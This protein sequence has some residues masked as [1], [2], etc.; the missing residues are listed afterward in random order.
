MLSICIPVFNVDVTILTAEL[1]RQANI[2]KLP[3]EVRIYDDGSIEQYKNINRTLSKNEVVVYYELPRNLGSAAIR[4]KLANDAKYEHLLFLDSD[5]DIPED[6][7]TNYQK[8]INQEFMIVCGG[9]VHPQNLP[10]S[11]YSLRWYVGKKREDFNAKTR[12][13]IPNK[14]FMSNNFMVKK[15]LFDTIRFNEEIKR[16]GHEDTMFGMELEKHNIQIH[17]ID[18]AL[19]HI[20]LENNQEFIQKTK[21][22]IDTLKYLEKYHHNNPL[23]YKRITLLKYAQWVET[24]SLQKRFRWFYNRYQNKLENHLSSNKPNLYIYDLYKLSYYTTLQ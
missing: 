6:Y 1:I 8:Y 12:S 10:S 11:E 18:N 7:L 20:G 5:S 24:L 16:S 21:Q 13:I 19:T 3:I 15:S 2:I 17:H 14:S 22:R 9:R 23:L 4:N